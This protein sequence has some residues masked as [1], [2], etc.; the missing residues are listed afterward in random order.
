MSGGLLKLV[1]LIQAAWN[2]LKPYAAIYPWEKGARLRLG[3]Y[4]STLPPGYYLKWPIF[5][6]VNSVITAAT[7]MR[8]P[9]QTVKNVTFR[10]T[11]KYK[12][13]DCESWTTDIYE[14]TSFLRDVC[15][16]HVADYFHNGANKWDNMIRRLRAE[17]E[18][19][20]FEILRL[21]IVDESNGLAFRMFGDNKEE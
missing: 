19:G 12:V 8:G 1:E 7:T 21:R 11:V 2:M 5:E 10:W 9:T 15:T 13:T 14:E 17:A 18:E 3:K 6:K 16:A 4:H 20:G